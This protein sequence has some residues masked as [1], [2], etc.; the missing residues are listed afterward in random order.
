MEREFEKLISMRSQ[1]FNKLCVNFILLLSFV[2]GIFHLGTVKSTIMAQSNSPKL[3]VGG[4]MEHDDETVIIVSSQGS[5][6]PTTQSPV[7]L[8]H[9]PVL[10]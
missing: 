4:H 1:S 10:R 3:D 9:S 7:K 8:I 6:S 5:I 2:N